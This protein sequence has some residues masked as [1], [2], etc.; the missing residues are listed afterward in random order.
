M[1]LEYR[2]T[3]PIIR[4]EKLTCEAECVLQ[5]EYPKG[6]RDG[7]IRTGLPYLF[8][9]GY[10]LNEILENNMKARNN[11]QTIMNYYHKLEGKHNE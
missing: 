8:Y 10:S 2:K 11:P 4:N 5:G 1:L 7:I 6:E 9:N 3:I